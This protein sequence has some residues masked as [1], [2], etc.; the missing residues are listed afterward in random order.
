MLASKK[1]EQEKIILLHLW[2]ASLIRLAPIES[3]RVGRQ[4]GQMVVAV[5]YE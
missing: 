1:I 5:R 3:P 4:Q 2:A